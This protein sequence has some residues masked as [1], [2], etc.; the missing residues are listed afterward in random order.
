MFSD[1]QSEPCMVAYMYVYSSLH[2]QNN[3]R[4]PF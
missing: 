2:L 1:V 3:V 4:K